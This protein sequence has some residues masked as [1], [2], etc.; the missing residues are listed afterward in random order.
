MREA[1]SSGSSRFLKDAPTASAFD[2]VSGAA[3]ATADSPGSGTSTIGDAAAVTIAV[4]IAAAFFEGTHDDNQ[5]NHDRNKRLA[6]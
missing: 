3:A 2:T 4:T 1:T 6:P 5:D